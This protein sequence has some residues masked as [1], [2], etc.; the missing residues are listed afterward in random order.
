MTK[1]QPAAKAKRPVFPP[2]PQLDK[3]EDF[4][5]PAMQVSCYERDNGVRVVGVRVDGYLNAIHS[6]AL[7]DYLQRAHAWQADAPK[8]GAR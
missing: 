6:K 7:A 4:S 2:L 3:P 8:K 1:K 5:T